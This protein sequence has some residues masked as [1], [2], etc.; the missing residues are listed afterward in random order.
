MTPTAQ[1]FWVVDTP[2]QYDAD[3]PHAGVQLEIV[4]EYDAQKLDDGEWEDVPIRMRVFRSGIWGAV[5]LSSDLALI[6]RDELCDLLYHY[7]S[8]IRTRPILLDNIVLDGY[9]CVCVPTDTCEVISDR[10]LPLLFSMRTLSDDE[11]TRAFGLHVDMTQWSGADVFVPRFD[12]HLFVTSRV[13]TAIRNRSFRY[14]DC[15]AAD[16]YGFEITKSHALSRIARGINTM[17]GM[18]QIR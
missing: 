15:V 18:P 9:K 17:R 11:L 7:N 2:W 6:M 8:A 1:S 10:G 13:A 12:S 14:L 3:G 16:H 4:S 5:L